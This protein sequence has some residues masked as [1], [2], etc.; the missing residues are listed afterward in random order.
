MKI[1]NS[2]LILTLICFTQKGKNLAQ[3]GAKNHMKGKRHEWH[4]DTDVGAE[5]SRA[6]HWHCTRHHQ[7]PGNHAEKHSFQEKQMQ[8]I[9]CQCL[10]H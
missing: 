5:Q 9:L 3:S 4:H 2:A 6:A 1:T 8:F 7:E 10:I